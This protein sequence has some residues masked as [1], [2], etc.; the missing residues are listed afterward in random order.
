MSRWALTKGG[1]VDTLIRRVATRTVDGSGATFAIPAEF[2]GSDEHTL[3]GR[4]SHPLLELTKP[5]M[6]R[7]AAELQFTEILNMTWF[8]HNPKPGMK[9]CGMC[10]TCLGAIAHGNGWRI[11]PERRV[12]SLLARAVIRPSRRLARDVWHRLRR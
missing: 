4:F 5:E 8:C 1:N 11:P 12:L 3:F 7:T 10:N 9:P 6:G 2:A